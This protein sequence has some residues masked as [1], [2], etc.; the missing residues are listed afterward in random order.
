MEGYLLVG[1]PD[2]T[3]KVWEILELVRD[4]DPRRSI[5]MSFKIIMAI[6]EFDKE[7]EV[8]SFFFNSR[9]MSLA[10]T[11]YLTH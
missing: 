3:K 6:N 9:W 7:K 10:M 4:S 2:K 8:N 5:H 11:Y 1:G